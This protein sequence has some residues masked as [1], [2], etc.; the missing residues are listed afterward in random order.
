MTVAEYARRHGVSR[1]AVAQLLKRHL[2]KETPENQR[3]YLN[4]DK[5]LSQ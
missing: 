4:D 2:R 1:Q 3:L 5:T